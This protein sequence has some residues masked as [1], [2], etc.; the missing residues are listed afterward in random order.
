MALCVLVVDD[1]SGFRRQTRLLLEDAGY[2]VVGEATDATTAITRA[3]QLRP[4]VVLVDIGLPDRDGFFV[5]EVLGAQATPP[6]VVLVSGREVSDY[7]ARV[8]ASGAR[9]FLSKS[10]LSAESLGRVLANEVRS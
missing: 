10:E 9:G 7:G 2:E 8:T 6:A 5:A 4:D 1:H 3:R